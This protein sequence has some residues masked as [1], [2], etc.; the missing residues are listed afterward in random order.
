MIYH[1][2]LDE[3][4]D[5][6]EDESNQCQRQHDDVQCEEAIQR[7]IGNRVVTADNLDERVTNHGY[8]TK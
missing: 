7:D 6:D 8:R 2:D 5:M 4:G 1:R 3:N